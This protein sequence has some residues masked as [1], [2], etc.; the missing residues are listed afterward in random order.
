MTERTPLG[1]IGRFFARA[2]RYLY[3]FGLGWLVGGRLVMVEH[4][5]RVSGLPRQTVLEV[6]RRD[7]RSTDVAAAWGSKSDWLRNVIAEP[8]VRLSTGRRRSVPAMA[9]VLDHDSAAGVFEAYAR[10]HR[11]AARALGRALDLD[12]SD[13]AEVASA[14]PVVRFTFG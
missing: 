10:T 11:R 4:V 12:F 13:P 6:I 3:R 9:T 5:G 8:S 14:V 2:P 1:P 7:D